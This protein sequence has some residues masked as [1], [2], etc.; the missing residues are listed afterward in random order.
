M[1]KNKWALAFVQFIAFSSVL[2]VLLSIF[3]G[4]ADLRLLIQ[5]AVTGVLWVIIMFVYVAR[6][7]RK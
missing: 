5:S 3:S 7:S 6:K 1:I 4:V 2:Y